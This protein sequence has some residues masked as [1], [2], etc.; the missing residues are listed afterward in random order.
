[1]SPPIFD[2]SVGYALQQEVQQAEELTFYSL[3][4]Q[5][6]DNFSYTELRLYSTIL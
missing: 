2:G 3:I 1:M 4:N 5:L 6:R